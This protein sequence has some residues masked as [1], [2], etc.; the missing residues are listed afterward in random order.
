MR[1]PRSKGVRSVIKRG[2]RL[3]VT[4]D[5]TEACRAKSVLRVSGERLGASKA[6]R[7][8]AGKSRTVVIRLDR[9]VRRNLVAAMRQAGIRRLKATAVTKVAST[10]GMRTVRVKVQLK[11]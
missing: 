7:I 11:R 8:G 2:L 6:V 10:E 4:C 3:R 5:D 9:T 1:G